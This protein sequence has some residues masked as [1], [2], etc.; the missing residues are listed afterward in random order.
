MKRFLIILFVLSLIIA[1]FGADI[2]AEF[3]SWFA[4]IQPDGLECVTEDHGFIDKAEE[5]SLM[6]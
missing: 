2:I 6:V 4:S 1:E 3:G 5:S